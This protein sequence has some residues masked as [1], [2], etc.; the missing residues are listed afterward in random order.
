MRAAGALGA[1]LMVAGAVV[2]LA[3][4][5]PLLLVVGVGLLLVGVIWLVFVV[6]SPEF[7]SGDDSP[8]G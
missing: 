1:A 3:S 6:A 2:T 4:D 7:V 8:G 5:A